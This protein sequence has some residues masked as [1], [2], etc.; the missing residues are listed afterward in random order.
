MGET[1]HCFGATPVCLL[2]CHIHCCHHLERFSTEKMWPTKPGLHTLCSPWPRSC[3]R[4]C[5]S[6]ARSSCQ[7][8]RPWTATPLPNPTRLSQP[9]KM[10]SF[11]LFVYSANFKTNHRVPCLHLPW[12]SAWPEMIQL[13]RVWRAPTHNC[14]GF[15][16][17]TWLG[18]FLMV[19]AIAIPTLIATVH[20][21]VTP[22]A[23]RSPQLLQHHP[24]VQEGGEDICTV[25]EKQY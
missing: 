25:E 19:G 7:R 15:K 20:C 12:Q 22:I 11:L 16:L 8:R 1:T 13:L 18:G 2:N 24:S 14:P 9:E 3:T 5:S 6:A 10:K 23:L 17:S 4:P 21:I